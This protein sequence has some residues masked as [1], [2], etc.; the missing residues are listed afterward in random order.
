MPVAFH[1]PLTP[2]TSN[3]GLVDDRGHL[4]VRLWGP[5]AIFSDVRGVLNSGS[6]AQLRCSSLW[7]LVS[8][9]TKRP[10][11]AQYI[12]RHERRSQRRSD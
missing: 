8:L 9:W 12:T 11:E 10:T 7:T 6:G 2:S 4:L 3:A 5:S 1:F